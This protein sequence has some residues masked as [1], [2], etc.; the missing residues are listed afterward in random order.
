MKLHA[1]VLSLAAAVLA[2][3]R[4]PAVNRHT[5]VLARQLISRGKLAGA[6]SHQITLARGQHLQTQS[7]T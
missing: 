7:L 5:D 3:P 6:P 1:K 4:A 2:Q